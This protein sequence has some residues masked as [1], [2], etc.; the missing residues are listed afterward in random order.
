MII[1]KEL[2]E[3]DFNEWLDQMETY[4]ISNIKFI[5]D[6]WDECKKNYDILVDF[7]ENKKFKFCL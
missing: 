3:K 2:F 7:V 6:N 1:D 4:F 5:H